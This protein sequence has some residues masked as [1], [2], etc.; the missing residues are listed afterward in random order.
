MVWES[1]RNKKKLSGSS[2]QTEKAERIIREANWKPPSKR[3]KR[4]QKGVEEEPLK[5]KILITSF[6]KH[7]YLPN[8]LHGQ[9]KMKG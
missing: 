1:I 8:S 2:R 6:Y 5:A 9:W 7:I 3:K 4:E